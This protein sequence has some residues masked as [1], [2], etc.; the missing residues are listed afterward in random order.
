[1]GPDTY[2]QNLDTD[3]D[4]ML[5]NANLPMQRMP[6]MT[7]HASDLATRLRTARAHPWE[8]LEFFADE[9]S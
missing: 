2:V 3:G 8:G 1:M 6:P 9:S 5:P 7:I 4:S